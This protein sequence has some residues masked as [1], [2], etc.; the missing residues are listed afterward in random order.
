[1][2]TFFQNIPEALEEAAIIDGCNDFQVLIK[3]ILPL[4]TAALAV[5]VLFSA[6]ANWN[7]WFNAMI[8]LRDRGLIPLQLILREILITDDMQTIQGVEGVAIGGIG[9]MTMADLVNL[10]LLIRYVTVVVATL[11]ILCAYPFLQKYFVKG[12]L[13]GAV[14][15]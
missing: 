11:P 15:G 12:M 3:I 13:I 4:I 2:R 5:Q 10:Q 8:F 1:M 6:V 7:A 14:K 9:G